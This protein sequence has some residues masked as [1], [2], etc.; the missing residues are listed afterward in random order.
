[1][2][3]RILS[4]LLCGVLFAGVLMPAA[5]ASEEIPEETPATEVSSEMTEEPET[6]TEAPAEETEPPAM[7]PEDTELT[8]DWE[9]E[10]AL[11][12]DG[13]PLALRYGMGTGGVNVPAAYATASKL[14]VFSDFTP[15]AL[16]NEKLHLGIDVSVFQY[17]IDWNAV[18]ADGVEFAIIRAGYRTYGSGVLNEDSY[19]RR[20]IQNAK[21]AGIKVGVYIF[22]QAITVSEAEAEADYLMGL[23]KDYTVDLP[24]VFDFEHVD[25]GRLSNAKLSK[26]A[27]TDICNAFCARVEQ[28]GYESMVYS[29]PDMLSN[30]LY[31]NEL[32]RLW[33][34]HYTSK[35]SYSTRGYEYWQCSGNG[36]VKGIVNKETGEPRPVDLDFWFE[37]IKESP[38]APVTDPFIDITAGVWYY[39]A[40]MEAYEA[41]VVAGMTADTFVP[42]GI[43]TRA[44]VVTM[45]HRMAGKPASSTTAKFE[46]LTQNYYKDA[47]NWAAEQGIVSGFSETRFAPDNAITREQLVAILYR[48]AG[49]PETDFSL[50]KYTD[51]GAVQ[52]WARDAM[53]WAVEQGI[54]AG[55]E[56][57]T[58]R[59]QNKATRAQVCAIL[60][61]C[62]ALEQ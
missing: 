9:L 61:R 24:L 14:K 54:M 37:P 19:F 23:I 45:L 47:V 25:G 50:Q 1:M 32:G 34:A 58:L 12:E 29:N 18:R 60:M 10:G 36:T 11:P 16:D 15:R 4:V 48:M 26:R 5:L 7:E 53:A 8:V 33:L 59:P 38:P 35:T 30:N 40:V 39:D 13:D 46:D 31:P 21:A 22:S 20:N 17:D 49:S 6:E 56:D 55:F 41:G 62:A 28:K 42:G 43:A 51:A 27:A 52:S 3:T 2:K 57:A 44:Q